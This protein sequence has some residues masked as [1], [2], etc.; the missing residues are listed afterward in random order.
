MTDVN[1]EYDFGIVAFSLRVAGQAT[2]TSIVLKTKFAN[3]R[4]QCFINSFNNMIDFMC[5]F[6]DLLKKKGQGKRGINF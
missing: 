6:F 4:S 1:P 5:L 2:S 3:S